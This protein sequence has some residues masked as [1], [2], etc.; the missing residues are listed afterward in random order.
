MGLFSDNASTELKPCPFCQRK[1]Q[2]SEVFGKL[3]VACHTSG[4]IQP[5][6]WLMLQ[7]TDLRDAAKLWNRRTA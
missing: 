2:V 7:T 3:R 4:C 1:P 5:D 6:T